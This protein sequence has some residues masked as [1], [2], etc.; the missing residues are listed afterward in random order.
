MVAGFNL[1]LA[2][3]ASVLEWYGKMFV[4]MFKALWDMLIDFVAQMVTTFLQ[5]IKE[6]IA[7]LDFAALSASLGTWGSLP[8]EVINILQ[9]LH[10]GTAVGIIT[11][12]IGIR[13]VLQLIPFV[14]LGS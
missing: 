6:A 3:I 13:L 7:A 2:K 8:G 12:A 5:L 4:A 9:L 11:A 14:R 1:L 10:I